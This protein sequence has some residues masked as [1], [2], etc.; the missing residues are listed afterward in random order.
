[1]EKGWSRKGM[2]GKGDAQGGI[3]PI[4]RNGSDNGLWIHSRHLWWQNEHTNLLQHHVDRRSFHELQTGV[5]PGPKSPQVSLRLMQTRPGF[6]VELVAAEPLVQDPISFAWGPDGKLWV[7]EMGDYPL[8]VDGKGKFGGRVKVLEDTKGD[9]KY[10]RATVFLDGLPF[11]TSVLPWRK[12]VLITAAP[13]ILYAEDTKGSG[14]A[15]VVKKLF[16]GFVQGNQQHR[17]NTLAWGLDGWIYGANGDSGGQIKSTLTGK[18]VN[19]SGR[20]FRFR[21]ATREIDP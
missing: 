16:T 20:D 17:V 21:P 11:P 14:K 15:D 6:T 7:V 4:T 12:G 9:G 1:M 19:I 18:V 8:G 13:D 10:D 5:E 3:P 2:H